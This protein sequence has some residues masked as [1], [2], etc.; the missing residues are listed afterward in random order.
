MESLD[1]QRADED[2]QSPHHE[3][4]KNAPEQHAMLMGG[5]NAQVAEDQGDDAEVIDAERFFDHISSQECR[6]RGPT[7]GL[8]VREVHAEPV[9]LVT[10]VDEQREQER[11]P[12]PAATPEQRFADRDRVRFAVEHAEIEASRTTMKP[13]KP[14]HNHSMTISEN[15]RD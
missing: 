11:Q 9:P 10:K 12:D 8:R 1:E 13:M 6:R 5:R 15:P 7:V 4:S 3:R 14:S 2:H